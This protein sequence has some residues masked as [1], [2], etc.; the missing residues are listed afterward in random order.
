MKSRWSF[1]GAFAIGCAM[2]WLGGPDALQAFGQNRNEGWSAPKT[3]G[4]Y[5]G[6]PLLR[7]VVARIG[8]GALVPEEALY[9]SLYTGPDGAPLS[10]AHRYVL[11]FGPGELPQ[12]NAFWSM[13]LYHRDTEL[14]VANPLQRY[15][16]GDRTPGLDFGADGSLEI[17]IQHAAPPSGTAN[18]LPAPE[19]EFSLTLRAY[20]PSPE[21]IAG[22][23]Q[24]PLLSRAGARP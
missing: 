13:T 4:H 10:G 6:Q 24:M 16:I 3:L 19:G 18:W 2:A 21:M 5:D 14:L 17:L 1:L 9:Y 23:W 22:D 15:S 8:L 11:R 20:E 12:A 7:A